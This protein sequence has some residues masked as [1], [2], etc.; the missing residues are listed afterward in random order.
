MIVSDMASLD[1]VVDP[2][3]SKGGREGGRGGIWMLLVLRTHIYIY[4]PKPKDGRWS[5]IVLLEKDL[6]YFLCFITELPMNTVS[7]P[8]HFQSKT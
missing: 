2:G 6:F 3:F 7:F 4:L 1:A 5:E 8:D